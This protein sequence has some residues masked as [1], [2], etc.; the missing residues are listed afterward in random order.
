VVTPELPISDGI[1]QCHG[2][3]GARLTLHLDL[4]LVT[5]PPDP[6][7]ER[8]RTHKW[9]QLFGTPLDYFELLLGSLKR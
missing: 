4:E 9:A 1:T 5:V 7:R 3:V 6:P 8:L 2:L